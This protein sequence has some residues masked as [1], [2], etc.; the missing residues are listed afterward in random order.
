MGWPP[1]AFGLLGEDFLGEAPAGPGSSTAEEPSSMPVAS[2][3][4]SS[5]SLASRSAWV[6]SARGTHVNDVPTGR[7]SLRLDG[8][9]PHRGVLDLPV[10][11]HLL[12][13]ELRVHPDRDLGSR[14]VL[15]GELEAGDQAAVLRHVVGRDPDALATLGDQ[16]T[17]LGVLQYGAV[18]RWSGVPS[19]TTVRLD[20]DPP[21]LRGQRP[22]SPVRTRIRLQSS[23]RTTS[24]EAFLAMIARSEA[25]RVSRQPPHSRR[26]S[27]AAPTPPFCARSFS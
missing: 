19:G 17:G 5:A 8:Q 23:Q 21:V 10:A 25:F 14:R 3:S 22:D 12:D 6:F 2:R 1:P 7:E 24:S 27:A 20:D 26:R 9:R 15:G 18:R 11:A 16:V 4:P 13:D